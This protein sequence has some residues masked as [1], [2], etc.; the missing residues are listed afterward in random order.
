MKKEELSPIKTIVFEPP[1]V[2]A[3]LKSWFPDL[4]AAS[5]KVL[6]SYQGE[7][8]RFNKT[9]NVIP[10]SMLKN[11]EGLVVADAVLAAR[12]IEPALLPQVPLFDFDGGTGTPGLV[13]ACLFPAR[14]V[15]I[16]DRDARKLEFCNSFAKSV[17][18]KNLAVQLV[19]GDEIA[20]N[21]VKSAII[22]TAAPFARV[23]LSNRKAVAK[24]GRFFHIRSDG[25]ANE[26]ANMPSQV[27]THW[28]PQ[29]LGKYRIPE[30]ATEFFVV[31]TEKVS[32]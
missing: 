10:S 24:G 19:S 25:W 30:T 32:D 5:L 6:V 22:R 18:L 26:L 17:G 3:R 28:M 15:V 31:L 11:I 4:S 20:A 8:L 1:V 9:A 16:L 23:L 2:E 12:L 7:L 13:L 27:F 21:S 29:L 14:S